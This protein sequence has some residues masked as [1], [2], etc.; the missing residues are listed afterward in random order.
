MW[1]PVPCRCGTSMPTSSGPWRDMTRRMAG[2]VRGASWQGR[3]PEVQ[4]DQP[5]RPVRTRSPPRRPSYRTGRAPTS[6]PTVIR[7]PTE[8]EPSWPSPRSSMRTTRRC[9]PR[10]T[11]GGAWIEPASGSSSAADPGP[12]TRRPWS[13]DELERPVSPVRPRSGSAPPGGGEPPR[14]ARRR[15]AAALPIVQLRDDRRRTTLATPGHPVSERRTV[16][17]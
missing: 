7:I 1:G 2:N 8:A 16:D 5:G 12:S 10:S 13:D 3:P 15:T 11:N 17:P 6:A 4:P 14:R 9:P